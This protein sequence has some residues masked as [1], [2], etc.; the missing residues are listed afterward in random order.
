[1]PDNSAGPVF[2]GVQVLLELI[3]A[4]YRRPRRFE[5]DPRLDVR[6]DVPLPLV[7]LI[8]EKGVNG[9]LAHLDRLVDE[10]IPQVPHVLADAAKASRRADSVLP[11]LDV[12]HDRLGADK[13]G[14]GP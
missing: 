11:L 6:G 3:R 12:L 5:R 2:T 9:F 7:C 4:L 14:K 10:E 1:M 8:R 13:F